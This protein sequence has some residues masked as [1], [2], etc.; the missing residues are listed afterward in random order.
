MLL[1]LP[2]CVPGLPWPAVCHWGRMGECTCQVE[3]QQSK[4]MRAAG[5]PPSETLFMLLVRA[6]LW[7][8]LTRACESLH[9]QRSHPGLAPR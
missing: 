9:R 6:A 1:L 7:T 3:A 4:R 5:A 8:G 2:A